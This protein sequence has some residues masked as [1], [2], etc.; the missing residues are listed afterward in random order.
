M[1]TRDEETGIEVYLLIILGVDPGI[2]VCGY[3]IIQA[4]GN[5]MQCINYG[6]IKTD[7]CEAAQTRLKM[8]YQ[9]IHQLIVEYAPDTSAIES[10]F[11][12]RNTKTAMQVGQ[13]KGVIMLALAH[14]GVELFE[15]TPLQVKQGICGYGGAD[16]QQV[17]SM[18]KRLLCLPE[19]PKPDDAA[20]AL[21]VAICHAQA[22][23]LRRLTNR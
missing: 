5:R 15:Y 12:C 19:P 16:K 22:H 11:F 20:D 9:G 6:T 3:G 14:Q 10:L 7:S 4:K 13:A 18:V 17:Q 2:A 21:G 23:K 1:R 8:V